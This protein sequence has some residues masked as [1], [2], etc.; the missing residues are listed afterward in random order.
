MSVQTSLMYARQSALLPV[1]PESFQPA[2]RSRSTGQI[3][4][5]SS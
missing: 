4:Y 2:G 1:L 5:C 3:E